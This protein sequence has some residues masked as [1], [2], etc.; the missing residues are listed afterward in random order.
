MRKFTRANEPAVLQANCTKWNSQWAVLCQTNARPSFSWYRVDGK[1]A[2]EHILPALQEQ[3]QRHCSFCD[4]FPVEGVSNDT[5]EHFKPKTQFPDQ[6]YTWTNLYYCCDACQTA[7]R[8]QWDELLLH[9]DA[10]SYSFAHYFEFDFTTGQIRPNPMAPESDRK[11][12]EVTIALYG[13]DSPPRRRN[14]QAIARRWS[15]QVEG[16]KNLDE[17]AYRDYLVP[18]P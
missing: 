2:R 3:T 12:A 11:R 4:A 10:E 9:A 13:L 5:V 8:E 1:T 18:A 6:A 15:R 16:D 14:R 17:W 7:K